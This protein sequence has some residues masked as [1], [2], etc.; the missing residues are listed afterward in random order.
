[1]YETNQMLIS[2]MDS[3]GEKRKYRQYSV[4]EGVFDL[5][6]EDTA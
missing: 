3:Q 4:M 6:S 2:F 1:M 5:E